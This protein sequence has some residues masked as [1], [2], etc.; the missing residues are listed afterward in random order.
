[1]DPIAAD[2]DNGLADTSDVSAFAAS[3]LN[4][5]GSDCTLFVVLAAVGVDTYSENRRA[6]YFG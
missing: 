3:C 1:M 5:A 2:D 4:V 6:K